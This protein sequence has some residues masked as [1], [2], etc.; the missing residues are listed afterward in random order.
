MIEW[1]A[2]PA[3]MTY[4]SGVNDSFSKWNCRTCLSNNWTICSW[5]WLTDT[6]TNHIEQFTNLTES[7]RLG[8]ELTTH[9]IT[10][11][12]SV[13]EI[14]KTKF[15]WNSWT[16]NGWVVQQIP[17]KAIKIPH[18][19][20]V[21]VFKDFI[22]AISIHMSSEPISARMLLASRVSLE[23][24]TMETMTGPID[25]NPTIPCPLGMYFKS[26]DLEGF[27]IQVTS[28]VD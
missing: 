28:K 2:E 21:N 9:W 18:S 4:R 22:E 1:F 27:L 3:R 23:T 17:Y 10:E 14:F 7:V 25:C 19:Y 26:F 5:N 12:L 8:L 16:L 24:A 11:P 15:P 13:N 20:C 6:F